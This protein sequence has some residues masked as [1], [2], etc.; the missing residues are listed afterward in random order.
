MKKK[1]L[2][3]SSGGLDSTSIALIKAN[4]GH[5][6][7]FISFNYGQKAIKEIEVSKMVAEKL[8]GKYTEIDISILSFIFGEKNQLTNNDI[9]VEESY[10]GSIVVPLRNS[11]FTNIAYI[12]AVTNKYDELFLGSHLDDMKKDAAGEY[13]FPDSSPEFFTA[14]NNAY[15]LGKRTEDYPTKI[16]SAS[17]ENL[18]KK[19]LIAA[20]HSISAEILF[21]SWSCYLNGEKQCG[22]CDSCKNRKEAFKDANINDKTNYEL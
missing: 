10:K 15:D 17:L 5:Q 8:G 6:V 19:D 7:D 13:M 12:Y 3:I 20:A 21:Q 16:N 18:Y 9:A 22:N 11:V 14:L 1:I 4:E 2:I